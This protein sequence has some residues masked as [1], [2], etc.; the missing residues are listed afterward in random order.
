MRKG[1][2]IDEKEEIIAATFEFSEIEN[3][4]TRTAAMATDQSVISEDN[5]ENFPD[6]EVLIS[7]TVLRRAYRIRKNRGRNATIDWSCIIDTGFNGGAICSFNWMRKYMQYSMS[8]YP[9][10]QKLEKPA[11]KRPKLF[12]GIRVDRF[13]GCSYFTYIG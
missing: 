4:T 8:T 6:R 11:A 10:M 2:K 3:G 1:I 5:R 7:R 12:S 9:L 13:G